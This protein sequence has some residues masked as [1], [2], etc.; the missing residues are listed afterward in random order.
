MRHPVDSMV[1]PYVRTV[2]GDDSPLWC[3]LRIGLG[4]EGCAVA[5]LI[6]RDRRGT[7]VFFD[8]TV[9][10]EAQVWLVFVAEDRPFARVLN[11]HTH[12]RITADDVCLETADRRRHA[13]DDRLVVG[14]VRG[15]GERRPGADHEHGGRNRQ[16]K[17]TLLQHSTIMTSY[18]PVLAARLP[19]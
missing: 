16:G 19:M 6:Q 2:G 1:M 5:R 14:R 10:A 15:I 9:Y 3:R 12:E 17:G 7:R 11:M 18:P 8:N 4:V 13:R